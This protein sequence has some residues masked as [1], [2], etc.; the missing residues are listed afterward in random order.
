MLANVRGAQNLNQLASIFI[1]YR[2]SDAAGH[3]GRLF[4]RLE[5]WF[6]ADELFYDRDSIDSGDMFP[7]RLEDAVN[8]AKIVLVLI[9]P[10]WL[11][12]INERAALPSVDFVRVEVESALRLR[13]A[14]R[15][16]KVIPVLMGGAKP[17][18]MPELH[19]T[20]RETLAQLPAL[21]A[22]EFHGKNVDWD[23]QFVRLRELIA[24]VAGV[25]APRYGRPPARRN[26]SA[27]STTC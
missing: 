19:E 23:Q 7:Q 3:A 16:P 24:S 13:A 9:G 8:A 12:E 14:N 2:R 11:A 21:D 26:P 20:L 22:H 1:S 15:T 10:D 4:D 18:S 17:P 27:S 25:S 5:Q 6:G